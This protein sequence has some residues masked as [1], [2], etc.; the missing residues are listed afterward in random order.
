MTRGLEAGEL[1]PLGDGVV[2]EKDSWGLGGG[3][4]ILPAQV[5]GLGVLREECVREAG[6]CSH[7]TEPVLEYRGRSW[8]WRE[9]AQRGNV[10]LMAVAVPDASGS[11]EPGVVGVQPVS[12]M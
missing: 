4:G 5:H 6:P 2:G 11:G 12:G 1:G 10:S 7:R 9:Y 8:V 3:Y